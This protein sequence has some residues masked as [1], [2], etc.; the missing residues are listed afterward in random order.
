MASFDHTHYVPFLKGKAG[1]F[2]ALA[3]LSVDQRQPL[4]P[5]IDVPPERVKFFKGGQFQ[6]ETVEKALAGY[7]EQIAEAWGSVDHCF[8][9]LGGF[10]PD[11]R[12]DDGRHPLTAFFED[13]RA[14]GIAPIPV[15][16]IDRDRPQLDAV[17][18]V[19]TTWRLGAAIRLRRPELQKNGEQLREV[20]PKLLALIDQQPH[21]I[22]LVLD[23]GELLK[24]QVT[25]VEQE[26]RSV[27]ASFPFLDEWRSLTLC[28][29]AFPSQISDFVGTQ[30]SGERPR[31]DFN[32]WQRLMKSGA[33]LSRLPAFGD[34]GV[35]AADWPSAFNPME[36]NPSCKIIYASDEEWLIEKGRSFRDYGGEQYR[37]LAAQVKARPGFLT[38]SHCQT[39]KKVIDCAANRGGTGG[40]KEW[41]TAA[42]RHHI[43]VVS[44][45]LASLP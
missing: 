15:T 35:A 11:H 33:P 1:E 40:L 14:A 38:A 25:E 18:E 41:V 37:T 4:T 20:L 44:R 19:C 34:C 7:A 43:E 9:D 45:Q 29:G 12:M 13:A 2:A 5:L 3:Q 10:D 32:L 21:Q 39:E 24:S 42:T 26:A 31:R 28:S 6:I 36:M 8:V 23:F 30:S 27:I 22:D 16:G 17:R